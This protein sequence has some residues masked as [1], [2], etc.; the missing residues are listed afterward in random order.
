MSEQK[1]RASRKH[2]TFESMAESPSPNTL[3]NVRIAVIGLGYVGLPLA[4]A[5]AEKYD[6]LGFDIDADRIAEL[7]KGVDRTKEAS[8]SDLQL[9]THNK[10]N[11]RQQPGET[12]LSLSAHLED[13]RSYNTYIVTNQSG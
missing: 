5:F 9:V 11:S 3:E 2:E 7:K 8:L 6:V 1:R 12:G 4:I 10:R 13:L